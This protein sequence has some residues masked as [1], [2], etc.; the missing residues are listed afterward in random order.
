[1]EHDS[2]YFKKKD[3]CIFVHICKKI[4]KRLSEETSNS[5]KRKKS[6]S[7]QKSSKRNI[8]CFQLY[9]SIFFQSSEIMHT[10]SLFIFLAVYY[11]TPHLTN[12]YKYVLCYI[13]TCLMGKP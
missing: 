11:I 8:L 10:C 6:T 4:L 3:M 2:F 5:I 9:G 1:M 13:Y 7:V 12:T